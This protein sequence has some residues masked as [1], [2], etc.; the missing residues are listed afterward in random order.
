M[1]GSGSPSPTAQFSAFVT[2][3]DQLAS[4]A[5]RGLSQLPCRSRGKR[6][7]LIDAADRILSEIQSAITRTLTA[8]SVEPHTSGVCCGCRNKR[9]G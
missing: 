2:R 1:T 5:A 6:H 4:F 7:D 9:A 8:H 3:Q